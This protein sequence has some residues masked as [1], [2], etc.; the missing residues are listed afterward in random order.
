MNTTIQK[1][2]DLQEG[3]GA[4]RSAT[5]WSYDKSHSKLGFTISHFGISETEG[6]FTQFEGTVFSGEKDFSDAKVELVI[7]V[8]SINTEDPQRDV[9]LRSAEF[10]DSERFPSIIFRSRSIKSL[11]DNRFR[12]TGD[13]TM[14]GVTRETDLEVA[15]RGTVEDPF[16]NTK[17][18]FVVKGQ[19]DR[20]KFGLTW[21][22]VL[23]AGGLLV[24]NTVD[25]SINLELIRN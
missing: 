22:G 10:F 14:H 4:P 1:D 2:L 9:H 6:R 13:V 16:N 19:L 15:Y 20:T 11:G 24:G 17:A 3:A 5:K 23:A 21:N 25:L 7:D 8:A 12:L 18:G